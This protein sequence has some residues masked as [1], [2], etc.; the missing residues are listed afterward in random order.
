VTRRS[1]KTALKQVRTYLNPESE[2]EAAISEFIDKSVSMRGSY[3]MRAMLLIA[4]EQMAGLDRA[5]FD[6]VFKGSHNFTVF[7]RIRSKQQQASKGADSL[8]SNPP[9]PKLK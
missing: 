3:T 2:T 7:E 1:R 4:W 5:E 9:T 6:R 8:A